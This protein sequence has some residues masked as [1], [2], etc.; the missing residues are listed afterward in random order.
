MLFL[1]ATSP[2]VEEALQVMKAWGF[3]YRTCAVWVKDKIG[4]GYWFRQ[5]HELLL[6]GVRGKFPPP[7]PGTREPSVIQGD[8]TEHSAKPEIVR[9]LI[10]HWW[11]TLGRVELFCRTPRKGWSVWGNQSAGPAQAVL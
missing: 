8:R 2:K 11:P 3:T 5:Q 10:E 6:V 9:E 7:E 1:W 4:L